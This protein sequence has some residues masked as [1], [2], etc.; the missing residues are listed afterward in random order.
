MAENISHSIACFACLE[1]D[2][3]IKRLKQKLRIAKKA[4]KN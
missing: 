1:K 4:K 2:E 3:H